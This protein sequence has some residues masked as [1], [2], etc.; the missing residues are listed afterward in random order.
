MGVGRAKED[1]ASRTE[2][3]VRNYIGVMYQGG[4][5]HP[6]LGLY[7]LDR[8]IG[9]LRTSTSLIPNYYQPH[10]NLADSY[11]FKAKALFTKLPPGPPADWAEVKE[12]CVRRGIEHYTRALGVLKGPIKD[13]PEARTAERLVSS[14]L[15]IARMMPGSFQDMNKARTLLSG[16]TDDWQLTEEVSARVLYN[17]AVGG[18]P[19]CPFG[20]TTSRQRQACQPA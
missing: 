2:G 3:L 9:E 13:K 5:S 4:K 12:D 20:T 8:S 7:F 6:T 17:L 14:E 19:A 11:I 1:E 16:A 15:A 18:W 10:E